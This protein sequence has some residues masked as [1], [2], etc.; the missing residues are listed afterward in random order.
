MLVVTA[1]KMLALCWVAVP[2]GLVDVQT[3]KLVQG[4]NVHYTAFSPPP[5]TVART[6]WPGV[7]VTGALDELKIQ[8]G[9]AQDIA[10][11]VYDPALPDPGP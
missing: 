9:A 8:N 11:G 3:L 6:T 7:V 1:G 2:A 5:G 4:T 10:V